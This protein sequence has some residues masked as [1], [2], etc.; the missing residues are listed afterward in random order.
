MNGSLPQD[1]TSTF[2]AS[3]AATRIRKGD[4]PVVEAPEPLAPGD[5]CHFALPV[6]FGRRHADQYGHLLLTSGW[7]KFLGALDLSVT[8]SE[9]ADIQRVAREI[10][11]SLQDSRRLLRFSCHSALEAARGAL[12]AQ[13]LAQSARV[14]TA[15]PSASLEQHAAM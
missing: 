2:E 8:W 3:D 11:V 15:E 12:I 6:R 1:E 4:L 13:Q 14:H 5:L 10:V 7:L 9:I